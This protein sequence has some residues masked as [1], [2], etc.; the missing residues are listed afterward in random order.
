M[1]NPSFADMLKQSRAPHAEE[2]DSEFEG[3]KQA[4]IHEMQFRKSQ[5]KGRP[6]VYTCYTKGATH[7]TG[8]TM[9]DAM[10]AAHINPKGK[11]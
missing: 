3:N 9:L 5:G 2:I 4:L 1:S 8:H 7:T 6:V 10:I 11:A